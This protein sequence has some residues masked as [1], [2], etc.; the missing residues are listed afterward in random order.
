MVIICRSDKDVTVCNRQMDPP[1]NITHRLNSTNWI[2]GID[3]SS[4]IIYIH[5]YIFCK[6]IIFHVTPKDSNQIYWIFLYLFCYEPL[7][8]L[9]LFPGTSTGL[10]LYCANH[11]KYISYI[12][13]SIGT[14]QH[15][16]GFSF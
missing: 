14:A 11:L 3:S 5:N 7:P 2:D 15:Y 1:E 12:L 9:P 10:L 6:A 16:Y 4:P 13:S 8:F